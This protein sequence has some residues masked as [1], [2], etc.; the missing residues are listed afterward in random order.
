MLICLCDAAFQRPN[1]FVLQD[2]CVKIRVRAVLRG[3]SAGEITLNDIS[4]FS[5]GHV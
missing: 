5:M 4:D 1:I 3:E 2:E